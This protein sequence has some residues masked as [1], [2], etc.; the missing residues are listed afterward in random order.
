[1][2]KKS[3][4]LMIL[5]TFS[6]L[7]TGVVNGS[8]YIEINQLIENSKD[9]DDTEVSVQGEA[10]G[11]VLERGA[12]GWVNIYDGTNT[13]GI[14]LKK[15]DTEKINF[16]GDYKHKGDIVKVIGTFSRDCL[17]HG[18][19]VDI[20]SVSFDIVES[21]YIVKEKFSSLKIA[22]TLLLSIVTLIVAFVYFKVMKR[23]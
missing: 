5:F 18:G 7:L 11:E 22:V 13:I 6:L 2:G 12:Y 19:D 21:G 15:E 1:M 9:F 23:P 20:H 17:E 10:I 8:T 14:W 16:L 3:K 4:V